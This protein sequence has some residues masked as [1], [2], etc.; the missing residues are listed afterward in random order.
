MTRM[1][2]NEDIRVTAQV[3]L[4]CLDMFRKGKQ[5]SSQVGGKEKC[6]IESLWMQWR[7]TRRGLLWR[8]RHVLDCKK[9]LFNKNVWKL[10]SCSTFKIRVRYPKSY[11]IHSFLGC[12]FS[13]VKLHYSR[14]YFSNSG[15]AIL[16]L[17]AP[18]SD[19]NS[20]QSVYVSNF[21]LSAHKRWQ[22]KL[23]P[24]FSATM[25]LLL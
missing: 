10:I 7:R 11:N 23:P 4:R 25:L 8:E 13:H 2:R 9:A 12:L 6:H 19:F 3:E 14:I 16:K 24:V 20:V 5:W 17:P 1:D 21:S 15:G 18:V 22:L